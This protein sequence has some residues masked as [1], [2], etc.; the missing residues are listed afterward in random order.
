MKILDCILGK[1]LQ[2]CP[3]G[4]LWKNE[5]VQKNDPKINKFWSS[6]YSTKKQ[7][8]KKILKRKMTCVFIRHCKLKTSSWKLCINLHM[9]TNFCYGENY[10][11][12]QCPMDDILLISSMQFHPW[13]KSAV[14]PH[15]E[16]THFPGQELLVGCMGEIRMLSCL[17]FFTGEFFPQILTWKIWFQ[18][19]QRIFHGK[20]DPNLPDFKQKE[21]QIPRLWW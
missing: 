1:L 20:N 15:K 16:M 3:L 13:P 17:N 2:S 10:T 21:F 11:G 19:T 4:T 5:N 18:P 9:S 12:N 14:K 6:K 7:F 8:K